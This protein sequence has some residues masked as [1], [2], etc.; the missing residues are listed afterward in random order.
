MVLPVLKEQPA[1]LLSYLASTMPLG[2]RETWAQRMQAG[3]LL[4]EQ[5]NALGSTQPYIANQR[6]FY[7][8]HIPSELKIP[9]QESI[10]FEDANL[11]VADKPHFLPVTPSGKFLQETL[12]TR[13]RHR[14]G[15]DDLTPLHRLDRD[16]AGLVL[17][18]KRRATRNAY[19]QLFRDQTIHKTYEAIAGSLREALQVGQSIDYASHLEINPASFMQMHENPHL[20]ANSFT[21][22]T[23]LECHQ[24]HC[25]YRLEPK[26]GKR[27]QL[28]VHL[29]SLGAAIKGDHI[30]PVLS[31]EQ[32]ANEFDYANPLMLLAKQLTFND[33]ISGLPRHF[34]SQLT[35]PS[36]T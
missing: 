33:P 12:L 18:S 8:R 10:I 7:Y 15:N 28:R 24:Q 36:F 34:E 35:L 31:A 2:D 22:I 21:T 29:L 9:V 1:N 5:C 27:H 16:T 20:A 25:R 4:D 13:L 14:T 17:M 19:A 26:T 23:L 3:L 30:Y 32:T 11:L 6:I